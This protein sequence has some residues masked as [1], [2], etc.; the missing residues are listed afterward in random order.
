MSDQHELQLL[1]EKRV[2]E[3]TG[4]ARSAIRRDVKAGTFPAPV[5][6][7][8]R[9]IAW[10]AHEVDEWIRSKADRRVSYPSANGGAA[11]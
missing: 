7:G 2:V 10:Y 9:A 1:R 11:Q 8:E 6:I 5:K 3:K 4:L